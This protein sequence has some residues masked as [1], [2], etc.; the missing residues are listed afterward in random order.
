MADTET[1]LHPKNNTT[2][3]LKPNIVTGNIPDK[4]VT[5]EKLDQSLQ[6]HL[7][8]TDT[9]IS[10]LQTQ[11]VKEASE[12][13]N[14]DNYLRK[15]IDDEA[16]TR[17]SEDTRIS[18]EAINYADNLN[19]DLQNQINDLENQINDEASTRAS[20]DRRIKKEAKAYADDLSKGLQEQISSNKS[21]ISSLETR[22]KN[23][24][25]SKVI[26]NT[27]T[28][29]PTSDNPAG[30]KSTEYA[31]MKADILARISKAMRDANKY[32][33][34]RNAFSYMTYSNL[35][36]SFI[37]ITFAYYASATPD[38]LD[39]YFMFG[40]CMQI[41]EI[42][43]NVFLDISFFSHISRGQE[44][45]GECSSLV[46]IG[47]YDFENI[48][49]LVKAF[50]RCVSLKHIHIKNFV[51]SFDISASTQFEESDLVEIIGNLMDLTGKPAQT[52]TMGATNLAKLTDT[53]KAIATNKNW[54]L[55]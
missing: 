41:V 42:P 33:S 37:D 21:A 35:D 44:M 48:T 10:S 49:Y 31:I 39:A 47:A 17:E 28:F 55:A 50:D 1:N 6:D 52:L 54:T 11:I 2:V 18:Q 20:E 3:N 45:F 30:Q 51:A 36:F 4:A 23:L 40:L 46:T 14:Q 53:E 22:T 27:G 24:E 16:S 43:Y 26:V 32:T 19:S 9:A 29:N 25:D 7:S 12:R 15:K 5:K 13:T 34:I 8:S 38:N